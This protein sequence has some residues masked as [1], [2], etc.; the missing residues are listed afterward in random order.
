MG[1][2][3]LDEVLEGGVELEIRGDPGADITGIAYDSRRVN[4]G[5]LFCAITGQVTDG[6]RYLEAALDR[7]AA[8]LLVEQVPR[9]VPVPVVRAADSRRAMALAAA[10]FH[11]RPSLKLR[12][13]GVTGTKGK[14]TTAFLL[15]TI[16]EGA[17]V[18]TGLVGTV[19]NVVGGRERPVERTTPEAPDLQALLA[20]MV[21]AGDRA[22]VMEVS[23]H[24]LVLSRVEGCRFDTAVFTN[25]G[26]DHLDFH[27]SHEAYRDAKLRLF[28]GL[29]EDAKE[30]RRTAVINLDDPAA[31]HFLAASP[32]AAFTFG[33]GSQALV[34]GE[35]LVLD[36]EGTSFTLRAGW[37]GEP[38]EVEIPFRV[39]VPGRFNVYNSLAAITA[40]MAEGVHPAVMP[41]ILAGAPRVPGRLE[42]VEEGQDFTVLVDY[43]HTPDSL[44]NVLATTRECS[45]GRLIVVFGCGGDRDRGKRPLMG[46][47][48]VEGADLVVLTSDNPRSE[49][50]A[51]ILEDILAGTGPP[52]PSRLWVE[53]DRRQ[54]IRRAVAIAR[55]GD[56]VVLAGK[57]HET[58][59]Q[60]GDTKFP[61]DDREEARRAIRERPAAGP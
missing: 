4:R 45:P 27:P 38:G 61:F 54:A 32:V 40:G 41:E 31:G 3:R 17:G 48:A 13:V 14:T 19:A 47:V 42:K 57:G 60:V 35:D 6:H 2:L 52:D 8:A 28:T 58:Y 37:P 53:P 44:E 51:A 11:R 43:A 15:R 26:R 25:L 20:E 22:V 18:P 24:A 50:P 39:N 30:G 5:D 46:R 29:G 56:T 7:G 16:L 55:R 36:G 21:A 10:N 33:L 49:N 1:R 34:R 9:G 59:Q 12:V 23:S